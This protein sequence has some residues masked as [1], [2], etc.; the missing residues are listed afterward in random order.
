MEF[1]CTKNISQKEEP[2]FF[3]KNGR[4][5]SVYRFILCNPLFRNQAEVDAES[6]AEAEAETNAVHI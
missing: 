1:P 3:F 2:K 6:E 4:R 5:R